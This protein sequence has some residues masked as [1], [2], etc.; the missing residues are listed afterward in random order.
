[1]F[2]GFNTA[3][4]KEKNV[5]SKRYPRRGKTSPGKPSIE[6]LLTVASLPISQIQIAPDYFDSQETKYN[7][8]L[9][10]IIAAK[11]VNA[12]DLRS[13]LSHVDRSYMVYDGSNWVSWYENQGN[14]CQTTQWL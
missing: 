7:N 2:T 1:M 11:E 8:A 13:K 9:I 6:K 3:Q 4:L 12:V 14:H 10:G 5:L